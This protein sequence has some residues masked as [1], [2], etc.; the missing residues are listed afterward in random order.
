MNYPNPIRKSPPPGIRAL[1]ASGDGFWELNLLDGS[2]WFSD[3]F[4]AKLRWPA[5]VKRLSLQDLQ[6]MIPPDAW[7]G[8]LREIRD[9]LERRTPLNAAFRVQLKDGHIEWWQIRGSAER[10]D[11][12][13]PVY[14]A[15]SMR[16]VSADQCR[17]I[18]PIEVDAVY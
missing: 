6:P 18:H 1:R 3:W 14:L 2:A 17:G 5:D 9:H 10:N 15:G 16:D 8:L 4:Y 13:H 7:D 11:V 12:G